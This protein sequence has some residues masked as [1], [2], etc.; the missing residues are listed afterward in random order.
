MS[1][2]VIAAT[3]GIALVGLAA[4]GGGA[5]GGSTTTPSSSRSAGGLASVDPCK[6]ATPQQLNADGLNPQGTPNNDVSKQPGCEYKGSGGADLRV[7]FAKDQTQT[8]DTYQTQGQWDSYTKTTINGRPAA[9]AQVVGGTG[10]NGCTVLMNAGGGVLVVTV[11]D[12]GKSDQ[13][14][15]AEGMKY[16]QQVE[17]TM[18]K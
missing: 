2:S 6:I 11:T 13:Q 4:C 14:V 3:A 9:T 5:N 7:S 10:T 1:R 17:P 12:A 16:A 18:P 15:C 8:V